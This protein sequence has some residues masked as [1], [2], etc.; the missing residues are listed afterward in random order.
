[1]TRT[2]KLR[3]ALLRANEKM[4]ILEQTIQRLN[5][6]ERQLENERISGKLNNRSMTLADLSETNRDK[7]RKSL[8]NQVK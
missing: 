1:M 5:E 2:E 7:L 6:L 3:A 8:Y 4:I